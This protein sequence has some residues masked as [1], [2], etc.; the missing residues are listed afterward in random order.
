M[1]TSTANSDPI[2]ETITSSNTVDIVETLYNTDDEL[3]G[4]ACKNI[5]D[6]NAVEPMDLIFYMDVLTPRAETS[7]SG[8][9]NTNATTTTTT[10]TTTLSPQE[11]A[12]QVSQE[13]LLREMSRNFLIDPEVSRG[14][15]CFDL[16]VDGSTW[17]VQ[18]IFDPSDFREET[19]FGGCRQLEWDP[20]TQE[21]KFYEARMKGAYMG[22]P[23]MAKDG[24]PF[25]DVVGL[26]EQLI[27]GNK[28][29]QELQ[30]G[31]LVEDANG[32]SVYSD[33]DTAFL[34]VPRAPDNPNF[35]GGEDEGRDVLKDPSNI[36]EGNYS[37]NFSQ[38][39][40]PITFVG[41][42]LIA[43]FSVAFLVLGYILFQRRRS[44]RKNQAVE[45]LDLDRND[46]ESGAEAG[47]H[48]DIDKEQEQM[49]TYDG[50]D[51]DAHDTEYDEESSGIVMA[52]SHRVNSKE[53][54]NL[55]MS[56]EAIQMD[57][58]DALKG[59]LMG[60]HGNGSTPGLYSPTDGVEIE[61]ADD[62]SWAQTEG[63]I[64]SLELQLEP[65]TAEV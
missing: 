32:D 53:Y 58:G 49:D 51:H 54:P 42:L 45:F 31:I 9:A 14:V 5:L 26:L 65:I 28:I 55:P 16:P 33:Y 50:D 12:I 37:Q 44:Y 20:N 2:T 39:R 57:L 15:R 46:D 59:Q 13:V 11:N 56:A 38:N 40:T 41:G 27:D 18:M 36:K 29:V 35:Q 62:D 8:N 4:Y 19:L 21:C 63:T 17:I 52:E 3:I 6:S 61:N 43:C 64:G 30:G 25:G 24:T 34:G 10:T 48:Y 23:S 47:I 1:S 22:A 7:T 60:L